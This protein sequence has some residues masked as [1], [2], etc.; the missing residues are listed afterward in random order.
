MKDSK[1][2][3]ALTSSG[4]VLV[5]HRESELYNLLEKGEE[6]METLFDVLPYSLENFF[7]LHDE[8][9]TFAHDGDVAGDVKKLFD[10]FFSYY[11]T[12]KVYKQDIDHNRYGLL[13]RMLSQFGQK[14][15]SK[16]QRISE[17]VAKRIQKLGY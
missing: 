5:V 3:I 9:K 4:N 17:K 13:K 6:V 7:K 14:L 8:K 2:R 10:K 15:W 16:I 12:C 1:V 11:V